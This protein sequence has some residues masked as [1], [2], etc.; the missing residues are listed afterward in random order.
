MKSLSP[1]PFPG[2]IP[3][4][5]TIFGIFLPGNWARSSVKSKGQNQNLTNSFSSTR[6]LVN[7]LQ[8]NFGSNIFQFCGYISQRTFQKNFNP[9]FQLA[10]FC[11]FKKLKLNYLM[12]NLMLN[13]SAPISNPKMK[14][15]KACMPFS[16]CP[17]SFR[18]QFN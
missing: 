12:Q 9:D 14:N 11:I 6:F 1:L 8:K 2:K 3:L 4:L 15:Q 7:F 5:F 13:Q 10:S 16:N 18:D 17:F